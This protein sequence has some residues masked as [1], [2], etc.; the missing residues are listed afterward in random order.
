[1]YRPDSSMLWIKPATNA[2][3]A[4]LRENS[5]RSGVG[6]R[7]SLVVFGGRTKRFAAHETALCAR[8]SRSMDSAYSEFHQLQPEWIRARDRQLLSRLFRG[9][10]R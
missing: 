2:A 9:L 1:M 10:N 3:V 5:R 7:R 4:S 6:D 8:L